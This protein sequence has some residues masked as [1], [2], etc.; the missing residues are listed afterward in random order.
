M[1]SQIT[2]TRARGKLAVAFAASS[3]L[4]IGA[5]AAPLGFAAEPGGKAGQGEES[6]NIY[7][8]M[9]DAVNNG[10]GRTE[11]NT[12]VGSNPAGNSFEFEDRSTG[13]GADALEGRAILGP[14]GTGVK[15]NGTF[16]GVYGTTSAGASGAGVYGISSGVNSSGV[17][18]HCTNGTACAGIYG[19]STV[20]VG[21][22][23]TTS[24]NNDGVY[25]FSSGGNGMYGYGVVGVR[26]AS[27]G[28]TINHVGVYG[29]GI[30]VGRGIVGTSVDGIAL[31]GNSTGTGS[32]FYGSAT[33]GPGG[34]LQSN[35]NI[36]VRA[37]TG[38]NSSYALVTG[39]V[40]N[41]YGHT[42]INGN[43]AVSGG[44][45]SARVAT[46]QGDRLMYA[47]EA[48]TNLFSDQG[49]G[50][51]VNGRAVIQIDPLYAQTVNL[52]KPYH[53]FLTPRSFDTAGL[54]VGNLTPTSFEVREAN[55]GKGSYEF[56]W[57]IVALRKGYENH[58]MEPAGPMPDAT[59]PDASISDAAQIAA[60][61]LDKGK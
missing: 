2:G 40:P 8:L 4:I 13:P 17:W 12:T 28:T 20:G 44:T 55:G 5:L 36:G 25:G 43:F 1:D 3:V 23:G 56:S 31:L 30:G 10:T 53:V 48:T 14:S 57:R 41:F 34:I 16:R 21:V 54:T 26:G 50:R 29:S 52:D 15:G 32:G 11:V 18:G 6:P 27:I 39:G 49:F 35:N 38:S 46:N 9:G 19:T 61:P 42:L 24:S 33:N 51:L 37:I 59:L 60:P 22:W 58:R 45:K 47:E 7:Q